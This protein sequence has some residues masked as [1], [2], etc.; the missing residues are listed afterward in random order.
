MDRGVREDAGWTITLIKKSE[1][2][3]GRHALAFLFRFHGFRWS[4]V[5]EHRTD[6]VY[7]TN[8]RADSASMTGVRVDHEM[9]DTVKNTLRRAN[10]DTVGAVRTD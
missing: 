5:R 2:N 8:P 6:R 1:A 7:R 4:F 10:R 3:C 9:P